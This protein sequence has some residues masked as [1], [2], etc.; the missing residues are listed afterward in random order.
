MTVIGCFRSYGAPTM[1]GD[2]M[3]TTAGQQ[4][5]LRKKIRRLR[6]TMAIG[7]TGSEFAADTAT[8][9]LDSALCPRQPVTRS[10]VLSGR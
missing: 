2:F 6:P 1:L 5:G 4:S 8:V 3:I 9:A 10:I 7:W